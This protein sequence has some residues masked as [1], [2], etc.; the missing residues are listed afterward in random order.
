[1]LVCRV[2]F[3]VYMLN[4]DEQESK[5]SDNQN[6]SHS[7]ANTNGK[8]IDTVV[9]RLIFILVKDREEIWVKGKMKRILT[10]CELIVNKGHLSVCECGIIHKKWKEFIEKLLT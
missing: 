8:D 7:D 1:M 6:R 9:V 3:A 2:C 5:Q 4:V 10:S